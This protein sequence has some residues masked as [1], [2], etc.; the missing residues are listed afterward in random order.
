MI[1][2]RYDIGAQK[3]SIAKASP[4]RPK[5]LSS[6]TIK[7]IYAK[8]NTEKITKFPDG[9]YVG[10][11]VKNIRDGKGTMTYNNGNK[12]VGQWKNN[13]R[14]G[15]G[16]LT[17]NANDIWTG[18]WNNDELKKCNIVFNN[19]D[20][21]NGE[22]NENYQ[23][24]G[25]GEIVH[26]NASVYVG[27]FADGEKHGLGRF[28]KNNVVFEGNFEHDKLNGLGK[29]TSNKRLFEGNIRNCKMHG[30]GKMIDKN[31]NDEI[32]RVYE[33]SFNHDNLYGEGKLTF[34]N[35]DVYIGNFEDND[36]W[37]NGKMEYAN[38]DIKYGLWRKSYFGKGYVFNNKLGVKIMYMNDFN[39]NDHIALLTKN[40]AQYVCY[41]KKA[42]I[43]ETHKLPFVFQSMDDF[44]KIL[45]ESAI[46]I[47][48]FVDDELCCP[49]SLDIMLTPIITS[50]G[51]MFCKSTIMKC[52]GTCPLCRQDIEYFLPNDE[53]VA[54]YKNSTFCMNEYKFTYDDAKLMNN[55]KVILYKQQIR[56][57]SNSDDSDEDNHAE[58]NFNDS[59]DDESTDSDSSEE[60][61]WDHESGNAWE[62]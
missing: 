52:D 37:G 58:E 42:K 2:N 14:H 25:T 4:R 12:Y 55:L 18:T 11:L 27:L 19:K 31:D 39:H 1:H 29:I 21:Y 47:E 6:S 38:G 54:K 30:Y 62:N 43:V 33:G 26:R 24:H 9:T 32:E 57:D 16:K 36:F 15:D 44:K 46:T 35:G 10:D 49:I 50:C 20:V 40:N 17:N 61:N 5:T 7:N 60:I 22:I 41:M 59:S 8:K 13:K 53:I 23:P 51:H 56:E 45:T 3:K 34:A 48:G 28:V